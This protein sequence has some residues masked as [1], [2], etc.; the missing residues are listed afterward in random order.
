M[1]LGNGD[2]ENGWL[3]HSRY[4]CIWTIQ[5]TNP[6]LL[7]PLLLHLL[8]K[9]TSTFTTCWTYHV[10]IHVHL[11]TSL[12]LWTVLFCI[13]GLCYYYCCCTVCNALLFSYSAIFIAASVQN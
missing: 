11:C 12:R 7:L 2:M 1:H 10:Q 3:L 6:L 9:V 8:I 4:R 5:Q 13:Y